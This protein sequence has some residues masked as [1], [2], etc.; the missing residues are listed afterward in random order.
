MGDF[1]TRGAFEKRLKGQQSLIS[2]AV[3]LVPVLLLNSESSVNC[4]Q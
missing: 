4:F 1:A 3:I 2:G